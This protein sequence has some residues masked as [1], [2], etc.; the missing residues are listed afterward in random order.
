MYTNM[1]VH[2]HTYTLSRMCVTYIYKNRNMIL[3]NFLNVKVREQ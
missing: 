2:L 1:H 3:L